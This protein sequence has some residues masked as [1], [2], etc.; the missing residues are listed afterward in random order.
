MKSDN[1]IPSVQPPPPKTFSEVMQDAVERE[2]LW[3]D[4]V[5][6]PPYFMTTPS[7][8]VMFPPRPVTENEI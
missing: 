6:Q 7:R 1:E 4:A 8:S 2:R 3:A 5:F